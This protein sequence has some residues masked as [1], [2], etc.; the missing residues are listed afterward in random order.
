MRTFSIITILSMISILIYYT[1]GSFMIYHT[2]LH[3]HGAISAETIHL[4]SFRIIKSYL[5]QM[6]SNYPF[7][8]GIIQSYLFR[9]IRIYTFRSICLASFIFEIIL[10]YV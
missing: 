7:V 3:L 5:F 9:I 4:D 10:H 1:H 2:F 8:I 6:T